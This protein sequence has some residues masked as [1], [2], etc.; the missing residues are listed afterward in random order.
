MIKAFPIDFITQTL[1]KVFLEEHIKEPY[2]F[3]G[4]EQVKLVSFYEQVR[5]NNEVD[6]FTE[7]YKDIIE[8]QNH[9]N[10]I[11]LGICTTNEN[12]SFTNVYSA[13]IIPLTWSCSIRC[14]LEDRDEMNDTI[15]NAIKYIKGKKVDV[16][17]LKCPD[18]KGGYAYVPFKVGTVGHGYNPENAH[19]CVKSGDF[20]GRQAQGMPEYDIASRLLQLENMGVSDETQHGDYLYVDKL[21]KLVVYESQNEKNIIEGSLQDDDWVDNETENGHIL[22]ISTD[23]WSDSEDYEE[24]PEEDYKVKLNV[25]VYDAHREHLQTIELSST[26]I[27]ISSGRLIVE[28]AGDTLLPIPNDYF[29]DWNDVDVEVW[30]SGFSSDSNVAEIYY[31]D[32]SETAW[33][34]VENDGLHPNIIFPPEHVSF[35]EYKISFSCD[36][37]RCD[38]PFT[39]DGKQYI[40]ISFS[41]SATIVNSSVKLGNDLTCI[42]LSKYM[43]IGN[44]N[45]E[46]SGGTYYLDPLEMGSG[47][48]ANVIPLRLSGNNFKENTHSDSTAVQIKYS[49]ILS[50]SNILKQLFV[51]SR[52]GTYPTMSDDTPSYENT[53]SPNMIFDLSEFFCSWGVVDKYT[54]KV[55]IVGNVETDNTESDV[56]TIGVNFQI[57]G[58]E[59]Y[60]ND[61]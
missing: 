45:I 2:F 39:L 56:L 33:V 3:G 27:R 47:I 58:D 18:T 57:Q 38:T 54:Y 12:P 26:D 52:Y 32:D 8:Q 31:Y 14:L 50:D 42:S 36:S 55:K 5:S 20:I 59:N 19:P 46:L 60:G 37:T 23:F 29:N 7:F 10:L 28:F 9:T 49:F 11:G 41:G 40:N 43:I 51:Y 1:N 13:T 61:L 22:T 21:G 25:R 53:I 4:E 44:P 35:E 16:A 15:N 48:N 30:C 17:L 6:R 24:T 34:E